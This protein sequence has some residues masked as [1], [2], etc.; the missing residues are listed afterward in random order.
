MP[1][2]AN[3][4]KDEDS[5]VALFFGADMAILFKREAT[6][7]VGLV[8]GDVV[9]EQFEDDDCKDSLGKVIL[10]VRQ[11][12]EIWNHEKSVLRDDDE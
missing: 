9:I 8:D 12:R 2:S 5:G 10:S 11:F 1:R 6:T 3:F 4:R 7:W